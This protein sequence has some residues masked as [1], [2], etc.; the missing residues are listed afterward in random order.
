MDG[1]IRAFLALSGKLTRPVNFRLAHD[2]S[3]S[4][5]FIRNLDERIG[6]LALSEHL[7]LIAV[8]WLRS[9]L[10]LPESSLN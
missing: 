10:I 4:A 2:T 9:G 5:E 6:D 1:H 8:V 7:M 3:R